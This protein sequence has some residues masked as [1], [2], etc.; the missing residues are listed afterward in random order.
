MS[1]NSQ[2]ITKYLNKEMQSIATSQCS[3]QWS[4]GSVVFAPDVEHEDAGDEEERHHQDRH[5][6]HLD[7]WRVVRVKPPHST[8]AGTAGPH[9]RGGLPTSSSPG[10]PLSDSA[11]TSPSSPGS[12]TG[13]GRSSSHR[14]GTGSRSWHCS[15]LISCRSESSNI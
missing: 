4:L 11:S 2:L 1:H 12:S 9:G 10:L 6:P 7:T 3:L 15:D 13:S 8:A 14:G 5:W